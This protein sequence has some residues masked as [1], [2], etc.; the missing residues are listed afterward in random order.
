MKYI[1]N[2][3]FI[4]KN[5]GHCSGELHDIVL[6]VLAHYSVSRGLNDTHVEHMDTNSP[7]YHQQSFYVTRYPNCIFLTITMWICLRRD[8]IAIWDR[9]WCHR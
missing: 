7:F 4:N 6:S 1:D 8:D 3:T 9:I 2:A 5:I